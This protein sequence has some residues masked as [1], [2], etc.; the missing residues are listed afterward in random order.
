[1]F[2]N[3]I[4]GKNK[5][6]KL[7]KNLIINNYS[8]IN[9]SNIW[10]QTVILQGMT[11]DNIFFNIKKGTNININCMIV[12]LPKYPLLICE[13]NSNKFKFAIYTINEILNR[14]KKLIFNIFKI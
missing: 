2:L 11:V 8:P 1:M 4:K 10:V 12:N 14:H 5:V 6:I 9:D 13:K 3:I 7:T